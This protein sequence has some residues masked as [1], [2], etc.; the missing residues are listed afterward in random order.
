MERQVNICAIDS[1]SIEEIFEEMTY[2][3]LPTVEMAA[4]LL[5]VPTSTIDS[6]L[7]INGAKVYHKCY[8]S[9]QAVDL[10][11]Q[12]HIEHT[13]IFFENCLKHFDN[14]SSRELELY[15]TILRRYKKPFHSVKSWKDINVSRIENDFKDELYECA[16]EK[17][18]SIFAIQVIE[19]YDR[20]GCHRRYSAKHERTCFLRELRNDLFY[21]ARF[22]EPLIFS[23]IPNGILTIAFILSHRFHIFSSGSD[24]EALPEFFFCA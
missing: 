15:N 19:Q 1:S 11:A 3:C 13:K 24:S 21:H 17:L 14:L 7:E 16:Q 6:F 18:H 12:K 8:L 2:Q 22:I 23:S 20:I 10:I 9:K 4:D 5:G